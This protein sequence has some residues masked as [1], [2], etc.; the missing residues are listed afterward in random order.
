MYTSIGKLRKVT[1]EEKNGTLEISAILLNILNTSRVIY[2]QKRQ[3]CIK[4]EAIASILFTFITQ[5]I[6]LYTYTR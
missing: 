6:I 4:M 3:K 2:G 1:R 5:V